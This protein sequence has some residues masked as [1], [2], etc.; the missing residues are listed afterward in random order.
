MARVEFVPIDID[1]NG[2][3]YKGTYAIDAAGAMIIVSYG[4]KSSMRPFHGEESTAASL[5]RNILRN[6]IE[7]T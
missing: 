3:V 5:A 7:E 4:G 2:K 6:L 1:H